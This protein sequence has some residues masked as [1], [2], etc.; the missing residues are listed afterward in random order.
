MPTSCLEYSPD[1]DRSDNVA[2][3]VFMAN[4][5]LQIIAVDDNPADLYLLKIA[6]EE[7]GIPHTAHN[8]TDGVEARRFCGWVGIEPDCRPPDLILLDLNLGQCDG[9]EVLETIRANAHLDATP[10][11]VVSTSQRDE[12]VTRSYELKANA[13]MFKSTD[14]DE[15]FL[16]VGNLLRFWWKM[17]RDRNY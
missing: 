15:S 7:S 5:P 4:A 3:R 2:C 17:L 12:D 14:I 16:N 13:Y 11:I 8:F 1:L 10:V 6:F 9:F